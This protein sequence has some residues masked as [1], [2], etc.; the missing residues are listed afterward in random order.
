MEIKNELSALNE[1]LKGQHMDNPLS[2]DEVLNKL[3]V[4]KDTINK[5][6]KNGTLREGRHFIKIGVTLYFHADI[7]DR[8]FEDAFSIPE[9]HY[10]H[11]KNNHT[12]IE[13][14]PTASTHN[15]RAK[16]NSSCSQIN[17]DY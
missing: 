9:T 1:T 5:W 4:C 16:T 15:G 8:L 11:T 12:A 3:H 10:D 14:E 2:L 7:V 6:R 13:P 17:P